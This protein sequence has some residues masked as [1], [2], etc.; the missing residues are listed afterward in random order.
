MS[1]FLKLIQNVSVAYGLSMPTDFTEASQDEYAVIRL[2]IQEAAEDVYMNKAFRFR[3]RKTTFNTVADQREYTNSYD[4]IHEMYMESYTYPVTYI[5]DY[6][7]LL[8]SATR[9]TI[10]CYT[11]YNDEIWLYPTPSSVEE[12]TV[13]HDSFDWAITNTYGTGTEK[14]SMTLSD[15]EPN[16]PTIHHKIVE[17][18]A[19]IDL[20]ANGQ[21]TKL[22]LYTSKYKQKMADIIAES[23]GTR[24]ASPRIEMPDRYSPRTRY[25]RDFFRNTV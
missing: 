11:V 15:D 8:T 10:P 14:Q 4:I 9:L 3:E 20:F 7:A 21:D 13:M 18:K 25:V 19:L 22:A 2:A 17:Y 24:E 16:F 6:T 23:I 1:D 5:E 12:V